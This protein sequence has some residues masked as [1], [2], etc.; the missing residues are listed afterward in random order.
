MAREGFPLPRPKG[1]LQNA[2]CPV[3]TYEYRFIKFPVADADSEEPKLLS[4]SWR[5]VCK[6][7]LPEDVLLVLVD[8]LLPEAASSAETRLLKSDCSVLRVVF[9]EE[10]EEEDELSVEVCNCEINCSSLLLRL[11]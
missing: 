11:E 3:C 4:R 2:L 9:V 6:S 1:I 5:K 7:V 8:E 10:V